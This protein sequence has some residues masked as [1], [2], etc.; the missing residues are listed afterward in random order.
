MKLPADELFF[1]E[2]EFEIFLV[3]V[4]MSFHKSCVLCN[5][6]GVLVFVGKKGIQSLKEAAIARG[7]EDR[8][9]HFNEEVL[10]HEICRK[11]YVN[12]RNI[13]QWLNKQENQVNESEVKRTRSHDESEDSCVLCGFPLVNPKIAKDINCATDSRILESVRTTCNLRNDEWS[14]EVLPRISAIE[15]SRNTSTY[16]HRVCYVNFKTSKS[17]PMDVFPIGN[18]S[19]KKL[20]LGRPSD[21]QRLKAFSGVCKILEENADEDETYTIKQLCDLMLKYDCEP[22]S[23][24]FMKK[25]LLDKFGDD[26]VITSQPGL[27]DII[28]IS[29]AASNIVKEHHAKKIKSLEEE[30]IRILKAAAGIIRD[31]ILRSHYSMDVYDIGENLSSPVEALSFV[32]VKLQILLGELF[33]AKDSKKKIMSIGQT[34]MQA[35]RPR[36]MIA[37]LQVHR[38]TNIITD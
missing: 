29:P 18:D 6:P 34:V 36:S 25:M 17:K 35:V 28:L 27:S 9:L 16:Y 19:H 21:P 37:P 22:H 8:A 13:T 33:V 10:V 5:T 2:F 38:M 15:I 26:L 23:E 11:N 31:E 1:T 30:E 24:I 7:E 32:S 3:F 20:R 4:N 12:K 14:Q